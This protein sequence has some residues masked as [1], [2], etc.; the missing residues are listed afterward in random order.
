[1]R[2]RFGRIA[3]AVGV[4]T[5]GIAAAGL[6]AWP[7]AGQQSPKSLLPPGFG[8]PAAPAAEPNPP[9]Q[10][11]PQ[12]S[13]GAPPPSVTGAGSTEPSAPGAGALPPLPDLL[14]PPDESADT[15]ADAAKTPPELPEGARRPIES[16]GVLDRGASGFGYDAFGT[17]NGRML[18]T[19]MARLDAPIASRWVE[20]VLRR[21]LLTRVATPAGVAAPD[22]IAERTWLLL[23]MGEAD[24]ARM[25]AQAVDVDQFSPRM[26][27]VAAQVALATADPAGLCP[28]AAG[29]GAAS[30]SAMWALAQGMCAA[31]SGD[32][33]GAGAFVDP[34]R[35][36]M[37]SRD[38][39]LL[40]AEKV[41]GASSAGR[42]SVDID[43]TTVTTLDTWRF[44]LATATGV[45]IP[46]RLYATAGWPVR[47]WAARAPMLSAAER[48]PFARTAAALGIFSSA[49]LVDLYAAAGEADDSVDDDGS[50]AGRLRTAYAGDDVAARMNAITTFWDAAE[51]GLDRY[52]AAVLTARAAAALAPSSDLAGKAEPLIASMLSTGLD[53]Q[54]ER[55][56]A[57]VDGIDGRKGDGAWALLAVGAP[58]RVVDLSAARVSTFADRAGSEGRHRAQLLVA[59]LA[60]LGRLDPADAG[61]LSGTLGAGLGTRNSWTK[62]IDHAGAAGQD[63]TAALLAGIGMQTTSW[64]AVPAWHLYHIVAALRRAGH[65]P[66]ARMIAAEAITRT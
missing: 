39:D 34:L 48:I 51:P 13:P 18:T 2:R 7:V 31:L 10:P 29:G 63:A 57:I 17:A 64:D 5:V 50:A 36:K 19:L 20:I 15:D 27:Q 38:I 59:A 25:L 37:G 6:A 45:A 41:I 4:A 44:G 40:L 58:D 16:V 23:R 21:A 61:R 62:A 1:M 32:A 12:S 65:E 42:R 14:T 43:W 47:A 28:L 35:A 8:A 55:W 49:A 24:G 60:G 9:S 52:A 66:E 54:A 46:D 56:A 11:T 30:G 53:R 33:L 22:W 3:L 26:F